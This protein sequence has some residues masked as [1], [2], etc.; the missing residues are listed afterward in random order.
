MQEL[1]NKYTQAFNA[2]KGSE[3]KKIK[4][5][6]MEYAHHWDWVGSESVIADLLD[7]RSLTAHDIV[8]FLSMACQDEDGNEE[9]QNAVRALQVSLRKAKLQ[10]IKRRVMED[11][12]V[13]SQEHFDCH[14]SFMNAIDVSKYLNS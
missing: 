4:T 1:M 11:E 8:D 7:D 10:S 3:V 6:L 9:F 2:A 12:E 5:I 13:D 14:A